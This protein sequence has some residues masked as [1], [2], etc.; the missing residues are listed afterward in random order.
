MEVSFEGLKLVSYCEVAERWLAETGE[1]AGSPDVDGVAQNT[2]GTE[3]AGRGLRCVRVCDLGVPTQLLS[4]GY[5]FPYSSSA[6]HGQHHALKKQ[7]MLTFSP[8]V[9][10]VFL[11]QVDSR[12]D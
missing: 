8:N 10:T 3:V 1:K 6:Y 12:T 9:S 11:K 2:W 7:E 4:V 5:S